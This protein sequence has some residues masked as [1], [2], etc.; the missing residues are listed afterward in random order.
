MASSAN[1]DNLRQ[2]VLGEI[3][4]DGID[5]AER[6]YLSSSLFPNFGHRLGP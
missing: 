2:S 4:R 5:A 3:E 1:L 6:K